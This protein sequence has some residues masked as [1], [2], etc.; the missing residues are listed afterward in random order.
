[1]R[2]ARQPTDQKHEQIRCLGA[3]LEARCEEVVETIVRR[4]EEAGV[5]TDET[6][7]RI[8][9]RI[10]AAATVAL[11]RWMSGGTPEAGRAAGR[12][13]FEL[14]GQLAA[15]RAETLNGVTKRCLRWRDAVH[16]TLK[17][18]AKE[19]GSTPAALRE[20]MAMA[21]TTLD[22][23]LVR[24]CEVYEGERSR[25]EAELARRQEELAF[26]ATHDQLTGL[27]N[28]T[29]MLDRAEQM[30]GRARRNQ[31]PVAAIFINIDG[32]TNI[33]DTLGHGAGNELLRAVAARLDGLVRDTDALGRLGGDEFV[34]LAEEASLDA[35]AGVIAERLQEALGAPFELEHGS[36]KLKMTA[37]MG[38]AMG[39][40]ALAEELLRDAEIAMHRAK[41]DGRNRYVVFES[42]MQDV[43]QRHMELEMDLRAAIDRQEFFLVYQPTFDLRGMIPTG[44]ETLIRWRCPTRGVVGPNDFIP[45]LEETGLIV[46]VGRWVLEQACRRAPDQR[47]RQRLGAPA[48]HRRVRRGRGGGACAQRS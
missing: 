40:R 13:A 7:H 35:G 19:T 27:P 18:S 22:V 25:T 9:E 2:P 36:G 45:L 43:V 29:L 5:E 34:V 23:T 37:S 4:T 11:A 8:F 12:E 17:S 32:F 26:M 20:A 15:H 44:V 21:Q 14:F 16:E 48:R 10:G 6:T 41:W 33:N 38:V 3:A 24:M 28:R 39:E 46:Q 30:L 47:R 31:T 1:M 42:G